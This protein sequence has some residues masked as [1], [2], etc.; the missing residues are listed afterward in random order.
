MGLIKVCTEVSIP[1]RRALFSQ[2]QSDTCINLQGKYLYS[3]LVTT[4]AVSPPTG[5]EE[6]KRPPIPHDWLCK[7]ACILHDRSTGMH[8]RQCD[9]GI[10]SILIPC[11]RN[12][13]VLHGVL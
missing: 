7:A 2:T 4:A 1:V 13:T 6:S 8:Q 11:L 5:A 12:C 3:V 10:D 9:L